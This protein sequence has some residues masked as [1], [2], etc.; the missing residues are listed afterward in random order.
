VTTREPNKV[1]QAVLGALLVNN[2]HYL[3]IEQ[4]VTPAHFSYDPHRKLFVL[5]AQW[6]ENG[7]LADPVTL[8]GEI[9]SSGLLDECGGPKYMAELLKA[10]PADTPS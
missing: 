5:I 3:A 2:R 8:W 7:R 1:E 10:L 4:I 9:A 6:I